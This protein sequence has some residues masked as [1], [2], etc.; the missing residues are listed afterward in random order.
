MNWGLNG[1]QRIDRLKQLQRKMGREWGASQPNDDQAQ[2]IRNCY[3]KLRATVERAVQDEAL[4]GT[5]QRF[6][7]Y[8]QPKKLN[9]VIKGF[10]AEVNVRIQNL[11]QRC[12]DVVDAHDASANGM[13]EVPTPDEFLDDI[14]ELKSVIDE[15]RSNQSVTIQGSFP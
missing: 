11:Y 6:S 1:Y 13:K 2:E 8:I 12:N 14:D 10:T 4:A 9:K 15:I 3:S 5:V 7:D